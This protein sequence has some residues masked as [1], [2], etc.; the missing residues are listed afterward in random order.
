MKK[1][2][3]L[4]LL[5]PLFSFA[6]NNNP[7]LSISGVEAVVVDVN[8]KS[9]NEIYDNLKK[10]VVKSYRNPDE[11]IKADIPNEQIRINGYSGGFFQAKILGKMTDY[12]VMYML[13]LDIKDNK[14]RLSFV[15]EN[16]TFDGGTPYLASTK[17]WF[18]KSDGSVRKSSK[19][20]Y[21]SF[22]GSLKSINN[23]IY[24]AATGA[25]KKSNDDW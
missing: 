2:F 19:T 7:T 14:Y 25:T 11:V 22:N 21:D 9:A 5:I 13:T 4:A 15:V 10:W 17:S 24:L 16:I 20:Q 12:D 3:I 8:D 1:I 6:Q 23:S 18:K